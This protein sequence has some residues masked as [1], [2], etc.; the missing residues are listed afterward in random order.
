MLY[1]NHTQA[2]K[3][4]EERCKKIYIPGA[5]HP[6]Q[7]WRWRAADG[8]CDAQVRIMVL[9]RSSAA[10][11]ILRLDEDW[12]EFRASIREL[13]KNGSLAKVEHSEKSAQD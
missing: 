5:K 12:L 4:I 7:R 2:S 1:L 8:T 9:V 6:W 11:Y 10:V 13:S 3:G